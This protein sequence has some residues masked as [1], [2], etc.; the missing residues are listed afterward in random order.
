MTW[1]DLKEYSDF[2]KDFLTWVKAQL[3]AGKSVDAAA[4]EYKIPEKYAGYTNAASR[5][6]FNVEVIYNELKK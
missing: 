5:V 3:K 1:N 6:K 2:N 4:A